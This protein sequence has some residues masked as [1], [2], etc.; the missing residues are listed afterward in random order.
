MIDGAFLPYLYQLLIFN[1]H[2]ALKLAARAPVVR[3]G[4]W[5]N[6]VAKHH[7]SRVDIEKRAFVLLEQNTSI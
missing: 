6:I 2:Q 4:N 7:M 5:D 1:V 3:N